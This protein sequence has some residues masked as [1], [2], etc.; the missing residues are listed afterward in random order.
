MWMMSQNWRDL[1]FLHWPVDPADIRKYIPEEL[2]L[3]LYDKRAWIGIVLF[4]ARGTRPRFMLPL[5]GAANFLEVN[6]RT[7]VRY[8]NRSG[9]YFFS[10]D[11]NSK[12]AVKIASVGGFLPY[13]RARMSFDKDEGKILFRS[14]TMKKEGPQEKIALEYRIL[15]QPAV[16]TELEK[17]LTER[18]CLWT[19]PGHQLLRLD[20]VH[21][22][23]KLKYVQG[24]IL[25][26][27]MAP[28]LGK[29]FKNEKP[30]AHY[31]DVK[32]VRFFPPVVET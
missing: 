19:K 29:N 3:D 25:G 31:A 16:S 11:A 32:K 5:P 30:M 6:V 28:Y 17:W 26:N 12:L 15:P 21:K 27:T 23:W 20:I 2:E 9:V 24:E 18:Y 4:K 13:R 10:L 1:L 14:E 8:K 22:P 7:Y